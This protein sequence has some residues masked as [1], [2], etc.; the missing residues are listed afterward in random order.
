MERSLIYVSRRSLVPCNPEQ[1]A[2]EIVAT[3]R[4]RNATLNVTGA[5]VCTPR[6]FAQLLEG[7]I[8][9]VDELMHSVEED[10]RHSEITILEVSPIVRRQ[11]PDWSMAYD[12]SST[13]V[14][15]QVGALLLEP[16]STWSAQIGRLRSLMVGL[17]K[18]V[19]STRA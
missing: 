6:H 10:S 15:R 4:V 12:G 2:A 19:P 13:Y 18:P 17:A 11:L 8:S 7:P 9:A 5:L 3:A 14:A 16:A 1:V